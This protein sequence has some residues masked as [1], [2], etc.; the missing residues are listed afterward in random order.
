MIDFLLDLAW[1]GM[2]FAIG[3]AIGLSIGWVLFGS[4]LTSPEVRL[5]VMVMLEGHGQGRYGLDLVK[6]SGGKLKRGQVYVVLGF[7]E[8]IGVVESIRLNRL[9]RPRYRLTPHGLKVLESFR[10]DGLL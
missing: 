9:T 4:R 6:D 5:Q 3:R 8:R 10:E 7:L 1:I 2:W